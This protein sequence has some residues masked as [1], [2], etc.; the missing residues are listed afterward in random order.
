VLHPSFPDA[1]IDTVRKEALA[2]A[3][4]RE[5]QASDRARAL[6]MQEL[7]GEQSAGRPPLG[8][9]AGIQAAHREAL[10][11]FHATHLAP[12]NLVLAIVS[13]LPAGRLLPA[14]RQLFGQAPASPPTLPPACAVRPTKE[15]VRNEESLGAGQAVYRL[16]RRL[17]LPPEDEPALLAAVSVLSDRLGME[18]REKRGLAYSVGAGLQ[19]T[20]CGAWFAVGLGTRPESVAEAEQVVRE[21]IRKLAEQGI[22]KEDLER[23]VSASLAAEM[24]RDLSSIGRA[25]RLALWDMQGEGPESDA[26]RTAAMKALTPEQVQ[27]AAARHL[28]GDAF[29]TVVVR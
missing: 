28:G 17:D 13:P 23:L 25:G 3:T 19:R 9:A 2:G 11:S 22:A 27:G 6:L 4:R 10:A 20:E 14:L 7:F 15:A 26:A 5:K 29:V 24:R 1:E 18:V 16:A 12:A 21:E 8:T